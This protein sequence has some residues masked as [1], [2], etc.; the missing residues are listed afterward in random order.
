MKEYKITQR[1]GL[2]LGALIASMGVKG[3]FSPL[4]VDDQI[5][6][7]MNVTIVL[8][9][10]MTIASFLV[11][12]LSSYSDRAEKHIN[13]ID[14]DFPRWKPFVYRFSAILMTIIIIVI[15]FLNISR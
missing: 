3:L 11:D 14:K 1:T 15:I 7:I 9:S 5:I 6:T 10:I 12:S 13:Q 4:N 8:I 2:L